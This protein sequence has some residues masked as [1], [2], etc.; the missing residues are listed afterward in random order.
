M[1]NTY[2]LLVENLRERL[3]H[4]IKTS[5]EVYG[6]KAG[7]RTVK[8]IKLGKPLETVAVNEVMYVSESNVFD[9]SGNE[10]W[11]DCLCADELGMLADIVKSKK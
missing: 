8:S 4:V 2:E 10:Y 9:V 6:T 3:I 11:L 1:E 5:V 7:F